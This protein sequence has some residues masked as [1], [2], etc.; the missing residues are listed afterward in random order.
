MKRYKKKEMLQVTATLLKA[1][2]T[3]IKG[4]EQKTEGL[5]DVFAQCQES[6]IMLGT[7]VEEQ[8]A[9]KCPEKVRV[10]VKL[11]ERYC[12][13]VYQMSMQTG[14]LNMCRKF[15]K[16]IQRLLTQVEHE[17]R[18]ELPKDRIEAVFLPY[19]ASMWDS[20][21][22]VFRAAEAD[23]N[24]DAY[25]IPIP[26]YDR[27]P[28]GSLKQEHYEAELYPED[29]PI[30]DY[31]EY[32]FEDRM[33]DIVFIHNPYDGA[34][35]VTTVHPFFYSDNL[36]KYTDCLVYIPYYATAGG[37]SE[38]QAFCPAYVNADYIVIQ[39]EKYRKYFDERIA[40]EKFLAFG[41]PKFD[42]VIQKCQQPPDPPAEWEEKM[43]DR[44]VYFYNTSID[45]M[46]RDT[47]SFLKKMQYVFDTF[48][49]RRDACLLWR[50]HPLLEST[51]ASMRS[52]YL[53]I[54]R[55]LKQS[56]LEREIGILDTLPSI[57]TAIAH[58]DAYVGDGGTSVTS[59]FGVAGKPLFIL[60][61]KIHRLPQKDDWK[62]LVY[63]IPSS[64]YRDKYAV[65]YGNK[66]YYS[67][68]DNGSY[69][70]FCDLTPY[71]GGNYYGAAYEMNGTIYA[72]PVNAD[73][74]LAINGDKRIRKIK[75][76]HVCE[77]IGAFAGGFV[78]GE[79]LFVMPFRYP[80]LIRLD[81]RTEEIACVR[82]IGSF[83]Y[84]LVNGQ[85]MPCAR[86][87][88]RR[89]LYFL[90]TDG[91]R[92]AIMDQET[93]DVQV[94]E[95]GLS[96]TYKNMIAE[97]Q[98]RDVFWLL[99][100]EGTVVVRWDLTT[101]EKRE[102]DLCVEGL[103]SFY[104]RQNVPCNSMYFGSLMITGET[105]IF[106]PQWGNKFVELEPETG[107]VCEWNSPFRPDIITGNEYYSSWAFGTFIRNRYEE[108]K[109]QFYLWQE[110]KAY[111]IDPKS[112]E[113]QE[114]TMEFSY[115]EVREHVPGFAVDSQ[116][117]QY[118]CME[119]AF[120]TLEGFL[121]GTLPGAAFDR[122]KQIAEFAKINASTDGRCG[123]KVYE[124]LKRKK[125]IL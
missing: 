99:P 3:I 68:E 119:N 4:L 90:S 48:A 42:S 80:D 74:I 37:M 47:E 34:N 6:A 106:A 52:E 114:I 44:K 12:E 21:E 73:H 64:D 118:C 29:I 20:L 16:S 77:Q 11:L 57:E 65:T 51:F 71:A 14:D 76:P 82:Q 15:S 91:A 10:L 111:D 121:D 101:G 19:K 27:N 89:K 30:T 33:P 9:E 96:Q 60:D 100:F 5:Q 105:I 58:A 108:E 28:D 8:Y 32:H 1:N 79:Y 17:I 84:G 86:T 23:E 104:N 120:H 41:S 70:F 78:T 117:M 95:T 25:V 38:A 116:W 123:E 56:F 46:L 67:P 125:E 50:P 87:Y 63:H 66:L 13:A 35:F 53:G 26:Y 109:Y 110:R 49:A 122:Q 45:G 102:Y 59:L 98:S 40:D 92:L 36:K 83:N 115:E 112:G 85:N 81:T 75:F 18:Y 54:Y 113:F 24:T 22:S 72:V 97:S 43:R 39:A 7:A 62:G 94:R 103:K 93:L 124:F 2:R 31:R 61:N 107:V 55:K 69:R 88:H